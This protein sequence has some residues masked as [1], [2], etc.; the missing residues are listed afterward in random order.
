ML[1]WLLLMLPV[2]PLCLHL[3]LLLLSLL[4]YFLLLSDLLL[5]GQH[6]SEHSNAYIW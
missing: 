4:L 2:L 6:D 1:L 3:M 5:T